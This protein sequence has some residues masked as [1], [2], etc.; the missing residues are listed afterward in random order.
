M[1]NIEKQNCLQDLK[2]RDKLLSNTICVK[3]VSLHFEN[4]CRGA[5]CIN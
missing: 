3:K 1:K 2:R 5:D 4:V